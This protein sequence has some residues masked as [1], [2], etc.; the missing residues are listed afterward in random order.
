MSSKSIFDCFEIMHQHSLQ[1]RRAGEDFIQLLRER[2]MHEE[3]YAKG[4]E[5]IGNHSYFLINHGSLSDVLS[6]IKLESLE[7]A[8]Q[9]KIFAENIRKQIADPYGELLKIQAL[10]IKKTHAEGQILEKEKENLIERN[11]TTKERYAKACSDYE[12]LTL[13]MEQQRSQGKVEKIVQKLVI[14]KREVDS[15]LKNYLESVESLNRYYDQYTENVKTLIEIYRSHERQRL[16]TKKELVYK[17]L[18]YELIYNQTSFTEL[19]SIKTTMDKVDMQI[20]LSKIFHFDLNYTKESVDFEPYEGQHHAFKNLGTNP[21]LID[22]PAFEE[23]YDEQATQ[24]AIEEMLRGEMDSIIQKA[25]QGDVLTSEDYNHFNNIIKD[26]FGRKLWSY[27]LNQRRNNGIFAIAEGGFNQIG[28]LLRSVLNECD[29]FQDSQIGKSCIILSQTF[30]KECDNPDSNKQYLQNFILDHKIWSNL[31]F[32]NKVIQTSID[33][34][35]KNQEE[36]EATKMENAED[37][38]QRIKNIVFCQLVSY[39]HIMVNFKVDVDYAAQLVLRYASHY[40]LSSEI[41]DQ[42]M[43]TLDINFDTEKEETE[44]LKVPLWLDEIQ[45]SRTSSRVSDS[46][47]GDSEVGDTLTSEEFNSPRSAGVAT[48]NVIVENCDLSSPIRDFELK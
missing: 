17:L 47:Y 19:D 36:L 38:Q 23:G 18:N 6:A 40:K 33:E 44:K 29:R 27:C 26:S 10:N 14:C 15:N 11:E 39:G 16:E 41:I 37:T 4:L 45:M 28:L 48:P 2:A 12:Q 5:R 31:E 35:V 25:W 32:W 7:R 9:A 8:K 13:Q 3:F 20:D 30:Y 24:N 46:Q 21:P 22:L 42:L 43:V 34:E 1:R